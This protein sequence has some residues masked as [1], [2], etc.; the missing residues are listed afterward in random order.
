MKLL[1]I[2][3]VSMVSN[4]NLA[5]IHLRLEEIFGSS[6]WFGSINVIFVGD[7]L[8]LPP[9]KGASVFETANGKAIQSKLGC[10]S[11]VNIWK[12]TIVYDELTI[13]ER[14]KNDLTYSFLLNEVRC[15]F[16]SDDVI[17][18]LKTRVITGSVAEKF[19]QL[20]DGGQSPVCLFPTRIACE[21]LNNEMLQSLGNK[22][23]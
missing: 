16:P 13:N 9:V 21:E 12:D 18:T 14:Q 5:Y 2:D 20:R 11:A 6:D 4:I 19:Q 23:V 10:M 7:L 8:Q 15:G 1:I 17:N 3:E 22:V